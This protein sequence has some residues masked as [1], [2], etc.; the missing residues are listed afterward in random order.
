MGGTETAVIRLAE[1]LNTLGHQ[2]FVVTDIE[3]P[4]LTEPLYVPHRLLHEIGEVD[5]L[6]AVRGWQPVIYQQ[7]KAG[8]R[9]FWTGDAPDQLISFGIGDLRVRDR[10]DGLLCVSDW[11][12]RE[13]CTS[14]GFPPDRAWTIKNGVFLPNFA[15]TLERQRKRLIYSSTPFRG[16]ALVPALFSELLKRH[17]DAELHVFSGYEVYGDGRGRGPQDQEFA[18]IQTQLTKIPQIFQHGNVQQSELA[19]EFLQSSVLFYPNTFPETSCITAMEAMAG[20]CVVLSSATGALPETVGDTGILIAGEPGSAAYCS[21]FLN[22]ADKLLSDDAYWSKLS[23]AGIARRA[24]LS[25][26]AVAQRLLSIV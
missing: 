13:F 26:D 5:A 9:F 12:K 7:I 4:P 17:P 21:A 16:L 23:Q 20:G 6:I 3:N 25:W 22:A 10:I 24:E 8:K 11:Q 14:A 18:R 1:S 19:H 2:V 15:E